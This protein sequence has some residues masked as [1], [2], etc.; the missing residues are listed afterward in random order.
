MQ[1]ST[2]SPVHPLRLLALLLLVALLLGGDCCPM[3]R[4]GMTPAT[5]VVACHDPTGP[6]R[7]PLDPA[8]SPC[9]DWACLSMARLPSPDAV[10]VSLASPGLDHWM[11]APALPEALPPDWL[12]RVT[13][14]PGDPD[15]P[16]RPPPLHRSPVLRL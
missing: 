15:L 13:R 11:P 10:P 9:S 3:A 14:G 16:P 4:T 7:V 5:P 1:V 8:P 12:G 2:Q 6:D